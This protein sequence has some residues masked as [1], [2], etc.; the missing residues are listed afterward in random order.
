MPKTGMTRTKESVDYEVKKGEQV[1]KEDYAKYK[2]KF[3]A[4]NESY[5]LSKPL[6]FK[7]YRDMAMFRGKKAT[8]NAD[9]STVAKTGLDADKYRKQKKTSEKTTKSN[10]GP[11]DFRKGGMVLRTI[12]NRKNK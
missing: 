4:G 5:D 7:D 11:Q 10:K 8:E 1:S 6:S 3:A 2:E 9:L 12:D